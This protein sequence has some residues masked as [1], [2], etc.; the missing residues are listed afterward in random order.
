HDTVRALLDAGDRVFLEVSPHP[1]LAGAIQETGRVRSVDA[2]VTGTLRRGEGGSRRFLTSLAELWAHGTDPDWSRVFAGTGARRVDLPT[3]AF[4]PRRYWIEAAAP[5]TVTAADASAAFWDLVER[6]DLDGF[7]RT[8]RLDEAQPELSAV[9]PAL[10][11]YHRRHKAA[12]AMDSWRYRATWK[13]LTDHAPAS[14]TGTWLLA[15]T[16]DQAG[17]ELYEAVSEALRERGAAVEPLVAPE[18]GRP[19]TDVLA[20]HTEA[21]GVLSLLGTDET[22]LDGV[23]AVPAGFGRTL[24]LIQALEASDL[25]APLWCLTQGA[26]SIG[27]QDSLTSPAQALVWGLGRVAAQELPARWGGLVDL[28]PAP[29]GKDLGRLCAV[30]AAPTDEDQIAIRPSGT[31]GRR[32]VRAPLGDVPADG[33][34]PDKG[35]VLITGGTGALGRQVAR[36]MAAQGAEHLLLVSRQGQSAPGA[37]ELT[38]ELVEAGAQ[39]TVAACDIADADAL[40]DLVA[41]VPAAYPLTTVV[42]TAAVLDDGAITSLTPGQA[43]R[44]LRVKADAAWRLHELTEHLDLSAFVL[45]SSLAGTVGMAGQGNYAPG[46]AYLDAL[47]RHRRSRGLVATSVAWGSWRQGGMADRDAVSDTRIRHGVPLLP[48]ESAVLALEAALAHGDTDIVIADID[49]DRF[50]H[51]YTA[52]RPSR[53]L[54]ELPETRAALGAALGVAEDTGAAT[55][56]SGLRDRLAGLGARERE[57]QLLAAVRTQAAAVLGHDS[58]DAV[59]PRRQFLEIGLDSVTAVEL[60]NRLSAATGLRLAATVVFDCPTVADLA[61]HLGAELF[62]GSEEPGNPGAAELDQL[63]ALLTAMPDGAPARD[64]IARRLRHLLWSATGAEQAAEDAVDSEE[65]ESASNE[66]IFDFIEKEFGI[67]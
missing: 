12:S 38:A 61:R 19:W 64:D 52:T 47:A 42:H 11:A 10:S 7:A 28:P 26:V 53:L 29:D 20:A 24:P 9:L 31:F 50:A 14:L 5:R 49:W 2:L 54:D 59:D 43:D 44:V 34:T 23:P 57:R 21:A 66:E 22:P 13:P 65:L 60:R 41:S 33:W 15:A 30:V 40:R 51:A 45:F 55:A 18:E 25:A 8:L 17:S 67:S 63:E 62:G 4:Q 1:V 37:A 3:Y 56:P 35:T 46:N 32:I 39:V 16:R 6:E 27:E 36:R 58:A 48:P